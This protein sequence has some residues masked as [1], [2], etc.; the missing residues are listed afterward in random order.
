M[1]I[2]FYFYNILE[3]IFGLPFWTIGAGTKGLGLWKESGVILVSLKM[4][5]TS[6]WKSATDCKTAKFIPVWLFLYIGSFSGSS[7]TPIKQKCK[8]Y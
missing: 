6:G 7:L 8:A 5:S 4:A 2:F 1:G 3:N